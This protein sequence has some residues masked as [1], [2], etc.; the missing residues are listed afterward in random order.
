MRNERSPLENPFG[1]IQQTLQKQLPSG[2]RFH[3][4]TSRDLGYG[5]MEHRAILPEATLHFGEK[6]IK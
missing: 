5:M 1:R 6:V 2:A 3:T 4:L